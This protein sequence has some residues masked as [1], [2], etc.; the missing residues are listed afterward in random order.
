MLR[1]ILGDSVW[2]KGLQEYLNDPK[3]AYGTALT[4][5]L[6]RHL[7]QVSGKN[8]SSFFQK[9]F[10]GEGYPNYNAVWSQNNNN[11]ANVELNQTTSH[12]SV[13]FYDMPVELVFRNATQSKSFVVDHQ[14][15]GQR[16]WLN[17]GFVADTIIMD[18]KLWILS[19]TKT[20][21][22]IPAATNSSDDVIIYP[23]PSPANGN[24]V[25][26]NPTSASI[27]VQL[28]NSIGQLLFSTQV[29]TSGK[30]EYI[31]L[32]FT[33]FAKG[34]YW[35]KVSNEKGLNLVKKILH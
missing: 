7:E 22:K 11:W 27:S 13:S 31:T 3:L 15:S 30:D 24:V 6:Q 12:A 19:K 35:V 33:R 23:N 34:I 4:E 8:L 21:Q 1:W 20:S 17:V 5:D 10:Y 2:R 9:W 26:R 25:V 14:F 16:F 32:P 18:P 28:Y 29:Q